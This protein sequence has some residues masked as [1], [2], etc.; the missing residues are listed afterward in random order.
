MNLTKF[1]LLLGSGNETS[2]DQTGTIETEANKSTGEEI[3]E[4]PK[5]IETLEPEKLR[6]N[7]KFNLRK[8]LAWDSAFF[9]SDG[10]LDADELTTIIEGGDKRLK[11][12]LP[13][14]EEEVYRSMESIS[15]LESDNLSLDC[16]E[17][18]LFEDIRA[19]IQNS[20]KLSNKS[21]AKKDSQPKVTNTP[22]KV[23]LYSGKRLGARTKDNKTS[24]IPQPKITSRVNLNMNSLSTSTKRASLSANHAKKDQDTA[25]QAH[26][27]QKGTQTVKTITKGSTVTG[28]IGPRRG[29]LS[30]KP[31]SFGTSTAPKTDPTR[32]SSSCSNSSSCSSG[33][34]VKVKSSAN[35]LRKRVDSKTGKLTTTLRIP[36]TPSRLN[37]KIKPPSFS[38]SSNLSSSVS[39]ASSISRLSLES[40]SS[41]TSTITQKSTSRSSID[42]SVQSDMSNHHPTDR[43]SNKKGNQPVAVRSSQTGSVS[44]SPAVQPTGLRMPSPKI[45]FFDAGK[46][47]ARTPNGSVRSQSKLPTGAGKPVATHFSQTSSNGAKFGK[48]PPPKT[49]AVATNLKPNP[50]KLAPKPSPQQQT[51]KLETKT[52]PVMSALSGH[53]AESSLNMCVNPAQN[54]DDNS[55]NEVLPSEC[56]VVVKDNKMD[57]PVTD[58]SRTPFAVKNSVT[59]TNGTSME[60]TEK[61][62]NFLFIENQQNENSEV[63]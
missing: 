26:V 25:K 51:F 50:Q 28:V 34:D 3:E 14:I 29:V 24:S 63:V 23:D 31:S 53:M 11:N 13:G 12:C 49:S 43:I 21:S 33:T 4:M 39:P 62:V 42:T 15:T 9:T 16:L 37:T 6:K 46:S 5:L 2:V 54:V 36:Q 19:S 8:S 47:G 7:G 27:T 17:A 35:I 59:D 44:R 22:K 48:I 45:G 20:N 40:L 32:P 60:V 38:S 56:L 1:V 10:V 58:G 30:S 57:K 52:C 55:N 18:E 61:T 41:L